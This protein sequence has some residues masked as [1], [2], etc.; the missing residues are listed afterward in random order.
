[1]SNAEFTSIMFDKGVIE[2][3]VRGEPIA[4]MA[5]IFARQLSES[6]AENYIEMSFYDPTLGDNEKIV[7]TI[8]R[9]HGLTP[10]Q[11][12]LKAESER[13]ELKES[14]KPFKCAMCY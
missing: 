2:A 7:V 14:I 10:H 11:L 5:G 3:E 6:G 4:I 8:Q 13:D 1:M 9:W 12:R